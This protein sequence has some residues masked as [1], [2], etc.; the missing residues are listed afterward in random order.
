VIIKE[1]SP[2]APGAPSVNLDTSK[3]FAYFKA[4]PIT[5]VG[6]M[7]IFVH[8]PSVYYAY[9]AWEM[10]MWAGKAGTTCPTTT[11]ELQTISRFLGEV[12]DKKVIS[13]KMLG[14]NEN[15]MIGGSFEI[16]AY[17][18]GT[19]TLCLSLWGN[20]D[21]QALLDELLSDRGYVEEIPW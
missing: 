20:Y 18:K 8:N 2:H 19:Y 16:P 21:K 12:S 9:F 6:V 17:F 4:T 5:Y 10:R 15:A 1:G 14:A 13:V 7:D 3:A 11:P